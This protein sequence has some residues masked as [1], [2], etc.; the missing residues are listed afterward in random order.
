M[1]APAGSGLGAGFAAMMIGFGVVWLAML[2]FWIV[3]IVD[4]ARTPEHQFRLAGSE[5]VVWVLL[6]VLAGLVGGLIWWCWKRGQIRGAVEH[7]PPG[8]YPDASSQTH[9]WWDGTRWW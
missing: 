4:V 1:T 3:S 8:W 5:K 9:R 6:V 2:A 7:P